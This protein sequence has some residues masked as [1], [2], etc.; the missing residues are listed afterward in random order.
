MDEDGY[1]QAMAELDD[2]QKKEVV[3]IPDA[4]LEAVKALNRHERRKYYAM[5]KKGLEIHIH[6]GAVHSG[7]CDHE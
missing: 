6:N 5:K 1:I 3:P 7:D 4:E 2:L